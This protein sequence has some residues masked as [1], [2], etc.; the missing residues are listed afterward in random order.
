M[1]VDLCVYPLRDLDVILGTDWL[2]RYHIHLDCAQRT[3]PRPGCGVLEIV[4]ARSEESSKFRLLTYVEGEKWIN[5]RGTLGVQDFLDVF[6]SDV[7]GIPPMREFEVVID[8]TPRTSSFSMVPYRMAPVEL[9][10]LK[11]QL[12]DLTSEGFIRQ[13]IS[14]RGTDTVGEE[15]G[16]EV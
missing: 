15:E 13:R 10:E 16:W 14:G 4:A 5:V 12:D 8:L 11:V 7:S 1:C 2:S 3:I 6:P 9:A